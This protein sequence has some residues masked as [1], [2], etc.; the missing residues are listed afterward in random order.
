[1]TAQVLDR[2]CFVLHGNRAA[3][4]A[5]SG[6]SWALPLDNMLLPTLKEDVARC[7]TGVPADAVF[8]LQLPKV[9]TVGALAI[10][11][12]TLPAGAKARLTWRRA[13]AVVGPSPEWVA[14][15]PRA[16]RTRNLSYDEAEWWTGRPSA[17]LRAAYTSTFLVVPDQRLRADTVTME[18]DSRSAA[19]DLS[20]L[21]VSPLFRPDWPMAW[22]RDL[23]AKSRTVTDTTPGGRVVAGRRQPH[24]R[25]RV[26]FEDLTKAEA[27]RWLDIAM[28]QDTVEPLLFVPDPGDTINFWREVFLARLVELVTITEKD[29]GYYRV[30]VDLEE[31]LA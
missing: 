24:R 12:H 1:M 26:T 17:R 2:R 22:G 6:G 15:Y 10:V 13:G 20:Y 28:V 3:E 31:I 23:S 29:D 14:V 11:D 4:G 25:Q 27:M 18:I 7:T 9:M 21:F 19:F 5:L 16:T 8:T 30:V